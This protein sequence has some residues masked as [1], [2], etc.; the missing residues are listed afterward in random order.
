LSDIPQSVVEVANTLLMTMAAELRGTDTDFDVMQIAA[1]AILEERERCRR[2]VRE[3]ANA[4]EHDGI[5]VEVIEKID[6]GEV[7]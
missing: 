2:I 3:V 6:N 5:V 1:R 4:P 7:R